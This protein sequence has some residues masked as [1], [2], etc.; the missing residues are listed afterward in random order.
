MHDAPVPRVRHLW[1]TPTFCGLPASRMWGT[2]VGN[3]S[4]KPCPSD[5]VAMCGAWWGVHAYGEVGGPCVG[6][7]GTYA[8]H[9]YTFSGLPRAPA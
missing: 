3:V 5:R 9:A 8:G 6:M 7:W 1:G 4:D 2:Y